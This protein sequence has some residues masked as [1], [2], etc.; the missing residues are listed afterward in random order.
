[1]LEHLVRIISHIPKLRWFFYRCFLSWPDWPKPLTSYLRAAY[2]RVQMKSIGKGSRISHQ[3]K[4]IAA[5]NISIG[6]NSHITNK[7][8]LDGRGGIAIGNDVLVGYESI[9]ITL[10]HNHQ[11]KDTLIRLQGA[12]C[13]PVLIGNDVW[14]GARVIILPGVRIGDGVVVGSGSVVSKDV[15]PFI[16]V[17]GSPAKK[18]GYR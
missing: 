13:K 10:T 9:I 4:I 16:I 1:M 14:L 2:W 6:H 12:Y 15:Q 5:P 3:V 7:V 8:I 17:A 18:I 11:D